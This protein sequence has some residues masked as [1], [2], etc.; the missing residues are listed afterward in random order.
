MSEYILNIL[1]S[2]PTGDVIAYY[3]TEQ[4]E[5]LQQ[6]QQLELLQSTTATAASVA[7]AREVGSEVGSARPM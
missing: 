7:R 4:C 5:Q 6:L 2:Q 1:P 3:S